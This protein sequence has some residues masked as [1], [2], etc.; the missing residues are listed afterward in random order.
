MAGSRNNPWQQL[1]IAFTTDEGAIR[2]A[3]AK[4]LREARP[5]E[6]PEAF[7][8]LVEARDRALWLARHEL[9]VAR[10]EVSADDDE[11]DAGPLDAVQIEEASAA[12]APLTI[13]QSEPVGPP[14]E[15]AGRGRDDTDRAAILELLDTVLRQSS[16]AGLPPWLDRRASS[17]DAAAPHETTEADWREIAGRVARLSMTERAVIQPDLIKRLSAY[18]SGQAAAFGAW[19]PASWPFFDLV[20]ELDAEFGWRQQDRIIHLYLLRADADRF[21]ALL[22]WAHDLAHAAPGDV[23]A[24]AAGGPPRV[25]AIDL[26]AFYDSGRDQP[27]LQAWRM[28]AGDSKLWRPSD[29]ATDLFFPLWSLRDGRYLKAVMGLL[30]WTGLIA[31]YTPWRSPVIAQ[32]LPWIVPEAGSIVEALLD[33]FPL[34]VALWVALGTKNL[35]AEI[36]KRAG[37]FGSKAPRKVVELPNDRDASI[38]FPFWALGRG[39]YLRG[40][41]GLLAWGALIHAVLTRGTAFYDL[42]GPAFLTAFLHSVAGTCG[43]R[44]V[45]YKLLRTVAAADRAGLRD[46]AARMRYIRRWGTADLKI[47]QKFGKAATL[48]WNVVSAV[49]ILFFILVLLTMWRGR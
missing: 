49:G 1:G 13:E 46:P 25:R 22:A 27:G 15:A 2:R 29:S 44:W 6:D 19:P 43:Q 48:L 7:Q 11:P 4:R 41:I 20:A 38:F 23:A 16:D 3:Y 47:F 45:A 26:Y 28:M 42:A 33:I 5:D 14:S 36:E 35:E 12:T 9:E 39:L 37:F 24:S 18:A 30:G 17:A 10:W 21:M 34:V 31:A 40:V 32:A 8:R